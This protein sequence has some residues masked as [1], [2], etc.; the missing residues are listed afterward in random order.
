MNSYQATK[1]A[2]AVRDRILR[3]AYHGRNGLSMTAE[4]REAY[5]AMMDRAKLARKSWK[6]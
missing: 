2:L 1:K 6:Q 4:E 3:D 5:K